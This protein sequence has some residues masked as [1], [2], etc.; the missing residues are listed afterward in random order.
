MVNQTNDFGRFT[1]H[2]NPLCKYVIG[3]SQISIRASVSLSRINDA[4][5]ERDES[6]TWGQMRSYRFS[7]RVQ[8]S[9]HS[10]SDADVII[11]DVS[12]DAL[13]CILPKAPKFGLDHLGPEIARNADVACMTKA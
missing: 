1:R 3:Q 7:N 5:V 13:P 12:E 6:N 2:K 10:I 11:K 9:A 4:P 8:V